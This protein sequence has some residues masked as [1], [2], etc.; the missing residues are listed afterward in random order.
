VSSSRAAAGA[1]ADLGTIRV[2]SS[3]GGAKPEGMNWVTPPISSPVPKSTGSLLMI[4]AAE[5]PM[6]ET[7][8]NV[9]P[10]LI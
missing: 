5:K 3:G 6:S 2:A 10:T 8:I 4:V 7:I 1:A 9:V